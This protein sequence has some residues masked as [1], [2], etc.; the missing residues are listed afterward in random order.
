MSKDTPELH[1]SS[2]VREPFSLHQVVLEVFWLQKTRVFFFC[3]CIWNQHEHFSCSL[4]LDNEESCGKLSCYW[5]PFLSTYKECCCLC[6]CSFLF[7]DQLFHT[8]IFLLWLL[9]S[10]KLLHYCIG[11]PVLQISWCGNEPLTLSPGFHHTLILL[12][13]SKQGSS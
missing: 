8:C 6:C 7:W 4:I 11:P 13:E 5:S 2:D 9:F 1:A 3:A 10:F 12:V